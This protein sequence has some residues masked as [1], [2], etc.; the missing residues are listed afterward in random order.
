MTV[1][2]GKCRVILVS[3]R[4][5]IGQVVGDRTS[6]SIIRVS[7]ARKTVRPVAICHQNMIILAAGILRTA[8]RTRRFPPGALIIGTH[9]IATYIIHCPAQWRPCYRND[10]IIE[11]AKERFLVCAAKLSYAADNGFGGN[12]ID[13]GAVLVDRT[14]P[15]AHTITLSGKCPPYA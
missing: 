11:V 8:I 5:G 7:Y 15:H 3:R 12:A 9:E 14:E 4:R 6:G 10:M 13:T 1:R 2:I